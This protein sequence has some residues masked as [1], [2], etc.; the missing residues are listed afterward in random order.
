MFFSTFWSVTDRVQSIYR[1]DI[2][3][4]VHLPSGLV[5]TPAPAAET[6][7]REIFLILLLEIKDWLTE[8]E[9]TFYSQILCLNFTLS[10]VTVC[11]CV[12]VY[13]YIC[14]KICINYCVSAPTF[15]HC[16]YISHYCWGSSSCKEFKKEFHI[17]NMYCSLTY[18]IP[19]LDCDLWKMA[20][21]ISLRQKK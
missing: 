6:K 11:V 7:L 14:I 19:L 8:L 10:E 13:I 15:C 18:C 17:R 2:I 4:P 12:C 5:S 20:I 16:I 3:L 21:L 1:G 9:N